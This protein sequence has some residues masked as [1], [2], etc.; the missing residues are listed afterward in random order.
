M[1]STFKRGPSSSSSSS[2][3]RS[4]AV[5][6]TDNPCGKN[7]LLTGG[8]GDLPSGSGSSGPVPG[9]EMP[10][11]SHHHHPPRL[12]HPPRGVKP[13]AGGIAVVSTGCTDWDVILGGGH[14]LGTALCL[15]SDVTRTLSHC[16]AKYWCAEGFQQGHRLLVP[17]ASSS[18]SSQQ[19]STAQ[20]CLPSPWIDEGNDSEDDD[21]TKCFLTRT[22]AVELLQ[23]LPR[24]VVP[25][26]RASSSR[27]G[28]TPTA[29]VGAN[30]SLLALAEEEENDDEEEEEDK[31]K[32]DT[33]DADHDEDGEGT[34]DASGPQ[35]S[36]NDAEAG[37]T[38]AWQ[39]RKSVQRERLGLAS[40]STTGG[41]SAAPLSGDADDHTFC[42]SFDLHRTWRDDDLRVSGAGRRP[43]EAALLIPMTVHQSSISVREQ[44]F[45]HFLQIFQSLRSALSL[46]SPDSG[47][48]NSSTVVRCLLDVSHP[49][50]SSSAVD[51]LAVSLPLLLAQIRTHQ[52]PAV[53]LVL[54]PPPSPLPSSLAS[55]LAAAQRCCDA[56]FESEHFAARSCAAYPPPAE[57]RR[58]Q[59][60]L[61]V[62]RCNTY[63]GATAHGTAA[64]GGGGGGGHFADSTI[65]RRP[66]ATL[67]GIERNRRRLRLQL[68]HI[69]PEEYAHGGG[70][71][72]G[73]GV[74]SGAGRRSGGTNDATK[75]TSVNSSSPGCS[76][77]KSV[78]DF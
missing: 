19:P 36:H 67:Y 26:R 15:T 30:A 25:S 49:T 37:L 18:S 50:I 11:R 61:H 69:P 27:S 13:K 77:G 47:G 41:S 72:G 53:V 17:V 35:S 33:L 75:P 63:T 76:R 58:F 71:V 31:D 5:G 16:L 23:S 8:D 24:V 28:L 40:S 34:Y 43:D 64:G 59:G 73:G 22:Q 68:L 51:C 57:F 2:I 78:L 39:Y 12:L 38:I 10:R 21:N 29:A 14:P 60:L 20:T 45:R 1:A 46:N 3:A 65:S 9:S 54:L 55:S 52:W 48:I 6:A 70:S 4:S 62:K 74:R 44:G 42:H 32:D 66:A 7:D 56:V